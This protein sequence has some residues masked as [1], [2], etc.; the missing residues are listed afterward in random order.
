MET[1]TKTEERNTES[2][3]REI[4]RKKFCKK[5]RKT[6]NQKEPDINN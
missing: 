5:D 3:N 1:E 2:K 4:E 6:E